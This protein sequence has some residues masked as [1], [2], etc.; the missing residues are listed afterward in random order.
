MKVA[1]T[2]DSVIQVMQQYQ[3]GA[4]SNKAADKA[5][6]SAASNQEETVALSDKARDAARI[7]GLLSELPDIREEKV[8]D[9]KARI[10]Q[11]TYNVSAEDIA[12]RMVGESLLDIFA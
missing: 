4:V 8:R 10:E 1:N 12:N 11:G 9:I 5:L 3:R 7:K 6:G 2:K